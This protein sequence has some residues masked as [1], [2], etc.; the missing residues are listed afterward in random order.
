MFWSAGVSPAFVRP[1]SAQEQLSIESLTKFIQLRNWREVQNS[2]SHPSFPRTR[3]STGW[4]PPFAILDSR[5]RGSD[6]TTADG[7]LHSPLETGDAIDMKSCPHDMLGPVV[8]NL[9]SQL[10]LSESGRICGQ[11][12]AGP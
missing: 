12:V 4:Q 1:E 3:E 2:E 5:F 10:A 11:L 6:E 7:V 9:G 8:L